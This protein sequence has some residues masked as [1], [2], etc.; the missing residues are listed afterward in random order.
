MFNEVNQVGVNVNKNV[1]MVLTCSRGYYASD[2]NLTSGTIQWGQVSLIKIS[3]PKT[4][5][6]ELFTII[7][8]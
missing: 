5:K 8:T 3:N 7:M 4:I 6:K 1:S 2:S